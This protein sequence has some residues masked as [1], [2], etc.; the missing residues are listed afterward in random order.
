MP[1]FRILGF[2]GG[3][4]ALL[5]LVA[6]LLSS[7]VTAH[8]PTPVVDPSARVRPSD[9]VTLVVNPSE[10]CPFLGRPFD[11]QILPDGT[12]LPFV[13]GSDE[14]VPVDTSAASRAARCHR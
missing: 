5:A 1:T 9:R 7:S 8:Q 11:T 2:S 10:Q 12:R 14:V 6:V 4:V 13:L 3:I